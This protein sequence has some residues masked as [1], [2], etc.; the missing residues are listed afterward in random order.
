MKSAGSAL[1]LAVVLA[2]AIVSA[3]RNV[4]ANEA[5][6]IEIEWDVN[7]RFARALTVPARK[8]VEV[9]GRLPAAARVQ[10]SYDAG[11]ALDF[12]IHYHE[13]QDVR[14]PVRHAQRA[15]ARGNLSAEIEQ[16]YCWMWSNTSGAD[17]ALAFELTR[18]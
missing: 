10:W 12:N 2:L 14:Y 18:R 1:G 17:M 8:F 9:C 3:P 15:Q 5:G 16:D 7:G 13:G 4:A 11:A 6:L